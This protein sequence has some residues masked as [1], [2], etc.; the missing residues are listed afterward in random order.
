MKLLIAAA[1]A[2]TTLASPSANAE[3]APT[4]K[5]FYGDLDIGS[6]AGKTTLTSRIKHAARELCGG[7]TTGVE[8]A[9][10]SASRTCY[11]TAIADAMKQVPVSTSQFASR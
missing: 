4:A 1:V 7:D 11:R 6:P 9:N 3:I 10:R 5:V 8:L 2:M